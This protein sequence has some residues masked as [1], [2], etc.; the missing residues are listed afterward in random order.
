MTR[1]LVATVALLLFVLTAA[2]AHAQVP[3]TRSPFPGMQQQPPYQP[4]RPTI[5]MWQP[6]QWQPPAPQPPTWQPAPRQLQRH[7]GGAYGDVFGDIYG[8]G[9]RQ[10][11]AFPV[12]QAPQNTSDT[13]LDKMY[14]EYERKRELYWQQEQQAEQARQLERTIRCNRFGSREVYGDCHNW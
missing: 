5:P 12:W 9:E 11:P 4:T 10:R 13:Y 8:T 2:A 7:S 1:I 6:P 3:Y 14:R